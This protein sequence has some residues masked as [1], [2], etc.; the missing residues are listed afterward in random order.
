MADTGRQAE[1]AALEYLQRQGLRLLTRNYR[2][3]GG[4]IDLVMEQGPCLVFVEVRYRSNPRF[5][6]ALESVDWRKR[7]KLVLAAQHYLQSQRANRPARFD[8]ITFD[9]EGAAVRIKWVQNAFQA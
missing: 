4:E 9:A 5:G 7:A 1:Q 8:V 3:R 6:G 2:C